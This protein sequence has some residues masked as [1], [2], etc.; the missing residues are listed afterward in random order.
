MPSN[1]RHITLT[2]IENFI[3]QGT[4]VHVYVY[5]Q[6]CSLSI[7]SLPASAPTRVIALENTLNGQI[8]P[9]KDIIEISKYAHSQGI[10]M[11]LDGARIWHVA[12]ELGTPLKELCDPFDSV[13]LC[14]SKGLG[15]ELAFQRF[16][17]FLSIAE[18]LNYV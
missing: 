15:E 11:H 1:G 14:F 7:S 9:Q 16:S 18:F 17:M 2:D 8:Y 13:S 12:A 10:M 6:I 5:A 4:D 3:V